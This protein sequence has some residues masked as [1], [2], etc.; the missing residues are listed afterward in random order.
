MQPQRLREFAGYFQIKGDP[1]GA[2]SQFLDLLA[3]DKS[4]TSRELLMLLN[5]GE[6]SRIC[7]LMGERGSGTESQLRERL[8]QRCE[9]QDESLQYSGN[10]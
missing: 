4:L 7:L 5:I 10:G 2:S 8:F 1:D 9:K 6:L 3:E